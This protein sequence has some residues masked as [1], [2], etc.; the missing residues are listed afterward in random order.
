[1]GTLSHFAVCAV[2]LL[3]SVFRRGDAGV[4][5]MSCS[6]LVTVWSCLMLVLV[7]QNTTASR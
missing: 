4:L 5:I 2:L 6:I 3:V 7:L 1:M